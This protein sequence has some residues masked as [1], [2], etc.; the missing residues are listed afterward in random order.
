MYRLKIIS[1]IIPLVLIC[2][3]GQ[4][5]LS[6]ND[7]KTCVILSVGGMKGLAHIGAI[8]AIEEKGIS[9]D[10]IYGNSMGSVIGGIYAHSPNKDLKNNVKTVIRSYITE[11]KSE[12]ESKAASG[13]LF[14]A[15]LA[16]LSGG[17]LGWETMLG[18]ALLNT[19]SVEKFDNQRFSKVLNEKFSSVN[20]E[21]LQIPYATSYHTRTR[22]GIELNTISTGNLAT[23][24]SRSSNNP[25]I[26]KNTSLKH[27][28]PGLDRISAVPI[29]DA[30]KHFNPDIVIAINVTGEPAM[31]YKHDKC[32]IIEVMI[33]VDDIEIDDMTKIY[34][35]LD[36]YYKMGYDKVYDKL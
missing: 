31:Y 36:S 23:A 19:I 34:Q 15:G 8:D 3:T 35:I 7:K 22:S 28:D 33:D 6:Y 29:E 10:C 16:F 11:T 5:H 26:F 32:R 17:L 27:I 4:K 20:I 25:F 1:I 2:C 30:I 14:G 9:I 12:L 18:S 21:N 13:F 24:I